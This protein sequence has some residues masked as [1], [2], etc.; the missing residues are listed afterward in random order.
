VQQ[1]WHSALFLVRAAVILVANEQ[2]SCI[3]WL[4]VAL[5]LPFWLPIFPSIGVPLLVIAV[6]IV[7]TEIVRSVRWRRQYEL[8]IARLIHTSTNGRDTFGVNVFA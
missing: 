5:E 7:D 2:P 1:D 3:A 8:S 6:V 4:R